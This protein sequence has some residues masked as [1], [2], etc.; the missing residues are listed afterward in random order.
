MSVQIEEELGEILQDSPATTEPLKKSPIL[1]VKQRIQEGEG[2]A[3]ST[4]SDDEPSV[5]RQNL[6][7]PLT[8]DD[9]YYA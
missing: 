4:S 2:D 3:A 5:V 8:F 6:L 1:I 7:G 9:L